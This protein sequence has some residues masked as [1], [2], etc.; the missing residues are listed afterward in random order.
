MTTRL[1]KLATA[2]A[3]AAAAA[4]VTAALP[5]APALAT[6]EVGCDVDGVIK[7]HYRVSDQSGTA[8]C[9][10]GTPGWKDVDIR[11]VHRMEA[12]NYIVRFA[13]T[14]GSDGDVHWEDKD[15]GE[16][17]VPRRDAR[18]FGIEILA[19]HPVLPLPAV[20]DATS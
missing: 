12:G 18:V 10:A 6:D 7:V 4:A 17:I 3:A 19:G 11:R 5:A 16:F 14:F 13:Y 1:K 8:K 9:F 20:R 15:P 2:A